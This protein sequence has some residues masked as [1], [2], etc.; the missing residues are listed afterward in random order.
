[1]NWKSPHARKLPSA[2][3]APLIMGILNVGE[4]SFS[5][6]GKYSETTAAIKHAEEM[7]IAGTD[8]IDIGAESTRP[9]AELL[10]EKDELEILL[11]KL[12]AVRKQFPEVAISVDT[13]KPQVAKIAISEG[14]DIINDVYAIRK[15][16]R[17]EMAKVATEVG[18]PL[19]IT[20]C[21]RNEK[22]DG[23]FFDFFMR[24]M[25]ERVDCAISEGLPKDAI[26]VDV[27]VG[28]G[29]TLE[30]NFELIKNLKQVR[31]LGYP[32]L[33]GVSRKSMFSEIA[34]DSFYLRDIATVTV[35]A[36]ATISGA[37]D[38]LRV[39]DVAANVVALKTISKLI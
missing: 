39:H 18:A 4:Q 15:N 26:V 8:I 33:L 12:K 11:P 35:S 31:S 1:M 16:G 37:C 10:P 21:S 38:I 2:N 29:K 6:G 20:H 7:I 13:Y 28:F 27:G 24:G 34:E 23:D 36:F 3:D 5:D 9:Q 22:H 30:E 14:A 19:I 32:I 17:Y 25:K